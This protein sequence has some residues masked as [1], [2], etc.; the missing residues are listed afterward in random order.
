M[1][2]AVYS[3]ER[4]FTK[5]PC[6]ACG[7]P[8]SAN[9]AGLTWRIKEDGSK[10]CCTRNCALHTQFNHRAD[11]SDKMY[12]KLVNAIPYQF[13]KEN[14]IFKLVETMSDKHADL[15]VINK[16]K[17]E[18]ALECLLIELSDWGVVEA[19]VRHLA[20]KHFIKMFNHYAKEAREKR[21]FE[22]KVAADQATHEKVLAEMGPLQKGDVVK[23]RGEWTLLGD[24]LEVFGNTYVISWRDSGSVPFRIT[25]ER[26]YAY[27]EKK[28]QNMPPIHNE[29]SCVVSAENGALR[30][31]IFVTNRVEEQEV[32]CSLIK[33][34]DPFQPIDIEV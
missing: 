30:G 24:V 18:Y 16:S 28:V 25:S 21:A 15:A 23:R 9:R 2:Y 13:T 22:A 1:S 29:P 14:F 10:L 33:K 8:L 31:R 20:T 32:L 4:H 3:E 6:A 27:L 34:L 17:R 26:I 19:W 7:R 11:Y 12:E 5:L